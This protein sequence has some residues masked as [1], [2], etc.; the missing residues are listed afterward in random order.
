MTRQFFA[1]MTA[2]AVAAGCAG[3]PTGTLTGSVADIDASATTT[4]VTIADSILLTAEANDAQGNALPT[5][6]TVTSLTPAIVTVTDAS[7]EP[8]SQAAFYVKGLTYG[9]GLVEL[10]QGGVADTVTVNTYPD[11]IEISGITD[12]TIRSGVGATVT[13]TAVDALGVAVTGFPMSVTV[14]EPGTLALDTA[15]KA[16][17]AI[18]AGPAVLSASGPGGITGTATIIVTPGVPA[19]AALAATT[20]GGLAADDTVRMKVVV[21]D[22]AGNENNRADEITG[23]TVTSSNPAAVSATVAIVDTLGPDD[24]REVWVTIVGEA[25]GTSNISGTVTTSSGVLNFAATPATV[26]NPIVT[27]TALATAAGGTAVITG[28]GFQAA[29]FETTVTVDGYPL[30]QVTVDSDNQLTVEMPSFGTAGAYDFEVIVGGVPSNSGTWTLAAGFDES[31]ATNDDPGTAPT[32]S[33]AFAFSGA[34]EGAPEEDDFF[35]FTVDRDVTLVIELAWT[36]AKDLDILVT[37]GAFTAFVCTDGATGANPEESVCELE[38]GTYILW[39]NDFDAA[40]NASAT[41]VTYTVTGR[42]E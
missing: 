26:L 39:L 9:V 38:A 25:S 8:L 31:E 11:H 33:A 20:F 42:I 24:D 4:R 29:G 41:P 23:A 28:S 5:A 22:A 30:G 32:I 40:A 12:N 2:A 7:V 19:S 15:T 14:D 13:L 37:D 18:L 3:D 10:T 35:I 16:V 1:L 34:F 21:E 27:S 6:P 17:T 36:P